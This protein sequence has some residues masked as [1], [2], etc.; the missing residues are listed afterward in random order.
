MKTFRVLFQAILIVTFSSCS[1]Q[2]T[3][4][5]SP[6]EI[7]ATESI[8]PLTNVIPITP[9]TKIISPTA[10]PSQTSPVLSTASFTPVPL[11]TIS[12]LSTLTPATPSGD[13]SAYQLALWTADQAN[14]NI[15]RMEQVVLAFGDA[16][17][18]IGNFHPPY[19]PVWYAAWNALVRFPDDPRTD[20]WLWKM[21]YYMALS[22]DG[23]EATQIYADL[24]A[25]ALN[26]QEIEPLELPDWF[27]TGELNPGYFTQSFLLEIDPIQI[28]GYDASY[29]VTIGRPDDID[30]PGGTCVLVVESTDQYASYVIHNGFPDFG[31]FATLRNPMGCFAKDVTDDGVDEIIFDQYTGG[32]VGTTTIAIY[33][34]TSLPPKVMPFKPRQDPNLSVWGGRIADYVQV[35]GKTQ[36]Q[37]E[38]PLGFCGIYAIS[39]YQWNGKWFEIAGGWVDFS[40][41]P[42]LSDDSLYQCSG[43]ITKYAS[44][45]DAEAAV[46]IFD[47]AFQM[48]LPQIQ[49]QLGML[50]EFR[51]SEGLSSAFAGDTELAR[52]VFEGIAY[53]P[54]IST[55]VWIQPALDFLESYQTPGDLYRACS[56][57]NIC[58]PYYDQYIDGG[59]C[60][61]IRMCDYHTAL[62]TTV[63]TTFASSPL[64]QI[65]ENLA[66]VGVQISSSGQFDF[67]GDDQDEVWLTVI[68]PNET[69]SELWIASEYSQGVEALFVDDLSGQIVSNE[70]FTHN[71]NNR[72]T[73]FGIGKTIEI[74]RHPTTGEPFVIVR[75]TESAG[76]VYQALAQFR[77]LRQSL[78]NGGSPELIYVRLLNLTGEDNSCPFEIET[79]GGTISS[80]YD[81]AAFYFTLAF[82]AELAG[83]DLDAVGW[84]YKV[85]SMYPDSS[86]AVLARLKLEG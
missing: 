60:V 58:A 26:G 78:Y 9:T 69:E 31:F 74:V 5:K 63:S 62:Q 54:T 76:P 40:H 21:A 67:D 7:R 73:S 59:G 49:S 3:Q 41:S 80:V 17:P 1:V 70:Q 51:V 6:V 4:T 34:V 79:E 37:I 2:P 56:R 38:E 12:A 13:P 86:F 14:D 16:P 19:R 68:Q 20:Q 36:I 72:L 8:T 84:Y 43:Q 81:C 83:Y 23:D 85:W 61:N 53:S 32:H 48:Y 15:T 55:S 42:D 44:S 52:S 39:D 77:G 11:S 27:Q 64:T 57:V 75:D 66:S 71:L 47:E 24:I 50:E 46:S 35:N 82:S 10:F 18:S 30:G 22:G 33:D 28:P 29:I 65:V 45:V 25:S